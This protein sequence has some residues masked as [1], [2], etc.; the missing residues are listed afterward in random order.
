MKSVLIV[1]FL[2]VITSFFNVAMAASGGS[3]GKIKT[4]LWYEGHIGVLVKQEGMS[5]LGGCGRADYYI[6][7]D[8]HPYFKEI[9]SLIL[10]AHISSQPL[11]LHLDGCVQGISRIKHISSNK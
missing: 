2:C 1:C 7:D 4:I 5:D 9:Y 8:K 3:S 10:S 11:N 6:L